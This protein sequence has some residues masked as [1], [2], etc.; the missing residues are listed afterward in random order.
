MDTM[1]PPPKIEL[2]SLN[3][4]AAE[5]TL[6]AEALRVAGSIVDAAR[7]LGTTRESVKRRIIRYR[8]QW[9]LREAVLP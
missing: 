4:E 2:Q 3:L 5:K 9:P 1:P 6:L 8:I 7:L